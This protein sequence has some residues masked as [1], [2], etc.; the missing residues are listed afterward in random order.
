MKEW[1]LICCGLIWDCCHLGMRA[2]AVKQRVDIFVL[3]FERALC[4]LIGLSW[5]AVVYCS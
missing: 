2:R 3:F 4:A 1:F 5:I